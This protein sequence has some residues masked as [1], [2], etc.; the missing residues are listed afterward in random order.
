MA[1]QPAGGPQ[2]AATMAT[3]SQQPAG[4]YTHGHHESVLASHRTRTAADSA[5]YLLPQLRRG[6]RVLDVGCGP[7]TITVDLAALVAPGE[8]VALDREPAVLEEVE[9]LAA[10]RGLANLV[11]SVGDVYGFDF[12]D[13]SFDMVHAHQVLQHLSDP[14]AALREMRRVTAAAGWVAARD[15][16]YAAMSWYPD[17]PRLERWRE[18]YRAVARA[19]GAEPDAGRRLLGWAQA[20]GL[21]EVR[22]SASVWLFADPERRGWWAETWAQRT[23]RSA[24]AS[25]ALEL[26]LA[27]VDE[28]AAMAAA[29][30]AWAGQPDAWFCVPHGEILARP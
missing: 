20:A 10:A 30:R 1:G 6:Q 8:V 17:E 28:L 14:V 29:W 4:R 26:G 21:R 3:M 5:A 2:R 23:E 16:D 13:S 19:N 24:L 9:R 27:S 22:P 11:T 25:R 15:G 12:P 7:G 18:V